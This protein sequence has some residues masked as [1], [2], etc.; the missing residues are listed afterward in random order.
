MNFSHQEADNK[1]LLIEDDIDFADTIKSVLEYSSYDVMTTHN[2]LEGIALAVQHNPM[3]IILDIF[4]SGMNGGAAFGLLRTYEVCQSIPVI[5]ITAMYPAGKSL[6]KEEGVSL[7][8][9]QVF[10]L[11]KPFENRIL[12]GLIKSCINN[13]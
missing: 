8:D 11:P 9:E 7:D 5:F 12:L 2:P 3:V 13:A 6:L 1:I 4:F 10:I